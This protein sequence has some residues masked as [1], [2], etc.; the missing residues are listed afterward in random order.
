MGS[1]GLSRQ[2]AVLPVCEDVFGFEASNEQLPKV[3]IEREAPS[4]YSIAV[5]E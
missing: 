4:A 2:L 1:F 3:D 5:M